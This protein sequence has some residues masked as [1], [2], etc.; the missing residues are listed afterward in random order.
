VI[1]QIGA[2]CDETIK[3]FSMPDPAIQNVARINEVSS[4]FED[5]LRQLLN[6]AP[7]LNC[8]FP[9]T[10]ERRVQ[11]SGYPDLRIVD[12]ASRRLFYL[13]PKIFAAGSRDSSFRSFYFEPKSTR[14]RC[15]TTPCIW[16]LDSSTSRVR[17]MAHGNSRDGI[18][19]ISRS[20][21]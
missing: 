19:S 20:S 17:K 4:Q 12:L 10:V 3:R 2:T 9:R 15:A 1:K 18:W 16:L 13:D 7:G 5:N 8:D 11:R 21:Q 14:T 6:A